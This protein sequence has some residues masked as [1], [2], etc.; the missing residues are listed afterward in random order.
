MKRF[1]LGTVSVNWIGYLILALRD[2]YTS[3]VQILRADKLIITLLFFSPLTVLLSQHTLWY[4]TPAK[5]FEEALPIG[6]GRMGAMV[7][8]GTEKERLSLN[9]ITLWSGEPV[10]PYNNPDAHAHLPAVREALFREDYAAADTLVRKLQGN[11]SNAYEPLGNLF[12]EFNHTQPILE[13]KRKLDMNNAQVEVDYQTNNTRFSR[14]YA[15]SYPDQV[16]AILLS[17]K[18]REKLNI[19]LKFNSPLVYKTLIDHGLLYLQGKAPVRSQPNYLQVRNAVEYMDGRGTRYVAVLQVKNTDGIVHY[20]DSFIQ[21][22][23][24]SSIELRLTMATSFNGFNLDPFA[25]GIDEVKTAEAQLS[26]SNRYDIQTIFKRQTEDHKKFYDRVHFDL[27]QDESE[28]DTYTRIRK[29]TATNTDIGLIPLYFNYGRYLL[30]SSSRTPNV[31]INLQGLWN[32]NVRPPWSSNYTVNINTEMNYWP[33]EVCNL[34]ELHMP[35]M[36]FLQNLAVTGAITANTYYNNNGWTVHHNTDI[37][38][39]SNPVGDFGKGSP[40]WANWQLG[41]AWLSTH[42]YEHYKFTLDHEFLRKAYPLLKGAALFCLEQLVKDSKGFLVTA[43]STSPE[44]VYITKNG[45][46]AS[47]LYGSTSDLSMIRELFMDVVESS[48]QL[49]MDKPFRD[50]L[51]NA[52]KN[53]YPYQISKKDGVLQEWYHDWDDAEITHRHLSHLF[54]VYPGK[55]ITPEN[56]ELFEAAKKSLLR[57]TNNGT[58]WSISWKIS[59]WARLLNADKAY[60][61]IQ[62][63]LSY[64]PADKSEIVMGGGGTYPN[65]FDAHPPFQIDGN[66][67]GTAGIAEMILQSHLDYIHILPA[68][69]SVWKNGKITGLKARGNI[70]VNVEW[71]ENKLYSLTMKSGHTQTRKIKYGTNIKEIILPANKLIKIKI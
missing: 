54:G 52:L 65:L 55:T 67:G 40:Q 39:M 2:R 64:Y 68:L 53:I 58:G 57:R 37:W 41:G 44:N 19:N 49:N 15:V 51:T 9:D 20:R 26:L 22:A 31:P 38:A 60:D 13:Y 23:E 6:N 16:I 3:R 17:S 21:V 27:S 24:A 66:F 63:L 69:P 59:M 28:D 70:E 61:A 34:P 33:V 47:T 48:I 4:K 8:G 46:K 35:L 56:I 25:K 71:K 11:F 12:I 5:Y 10:N 7:Y 43:P 18:G 50:S 36:G 45:F 62:K 30:I 14:K 29:N 32:E 42:L 1:I